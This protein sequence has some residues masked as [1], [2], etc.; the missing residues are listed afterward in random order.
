[1]NINVN[2]IKSSDK[3]GYF[4]AFLDEIQPDGVIG[5]ESKL[6]SDHMNCETFPVGYNTKLMSSEETETVMEAECSLLPETRLVCRK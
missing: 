6:D 5:T 2:G 3:R 4:H 1:M